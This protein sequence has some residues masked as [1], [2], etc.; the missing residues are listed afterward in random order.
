MPAVVGAQNRL[1][2]KTPYPHQRRL[3][4]LAPS[5][6]SSEISSIHWPFLCC[7][8]VTVSS[9]SYNFSRAFGDARHG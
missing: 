2:P 9:N 8:V 6:E 1:P 4:A 3:V 7:T 5:R